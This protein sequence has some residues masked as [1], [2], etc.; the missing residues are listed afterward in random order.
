MEITSFALNNFAPENFFG[1]AKFVTMN[2]L[3]NP[4]NVDFDC[5]MKAF[6]DERNDFVNASRGEFSKAQQINYSTVLSR[7]ATQMV[8]DCDEYIS[9]KNRL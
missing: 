9:T 3:K 5:I 2:T 6:F 7:L 8:H 1:E 4:K